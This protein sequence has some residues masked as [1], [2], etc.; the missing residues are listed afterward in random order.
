MRW[1]R[2][3]TTISDADR[4]AALR[5]TFRICKR[6]GRDLAG[7]RV[8]QLG[9][10]PASDVDSP[11][12][13]AQR[14]EAKEVN[15]FPAPRGT[16]GS[17]DWIVFWRVTCPDCM[18]TLVVH[19]SPAGLDSSEELRWCRRPAVGDDEDARLVRELPAQRSHY[20]K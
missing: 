16:S 13:L 17:A 5:A 20:F 4:N 9:V 18:Q 2:F 3:D 19:V 15:N 12:E 14:I 7:H 10:T 6:C 8:D 1:F 11:E